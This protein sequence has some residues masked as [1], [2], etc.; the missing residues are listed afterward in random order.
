MKNFVAS[1][2][3]SDQKLL[4]AASGLVFLMRVTQAKKCGVTPRTITFDPTDGFGSNFRIL[5]QSICV[6]GFI[7]HSSNQQS[8]QKLLFAASGLVFL[9]RVTQAKI[10]GLH[11]VR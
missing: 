5:L 9:M 6:K 7:S 10:C 11:R 3:Q 1:N 8:D 4:F 2:Q